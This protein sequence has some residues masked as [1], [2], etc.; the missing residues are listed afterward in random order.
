M[1]QTGKNS[2]YFVKNWFLRYRKTSLKL[3]I[4]LLYPR[5]KTY[6]FIKKGRKSIENHKTMLFR[7]NKKIEITERQKQRQREKRWRGREGCLKE[8][9]RD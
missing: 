2:I 6:C 8:R 4:S 7:N 3:Y 5:T 1:Q 9:K